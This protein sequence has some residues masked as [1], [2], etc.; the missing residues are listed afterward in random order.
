MTRLLLLLALAPGLAFA[1]NLDTDLEGDP[2][3]AATSD[4]F[5]D[6]L[7]GVTAVLATVALVHGE[8][9]AYPRTTFGLLGSRQAG[10]TGL[11]ARSLSEMSVTPTA[12]G[13][14]VRYVPLPTAPYVRRDRVVEMTVTLDDGLYSADYEVV[15]REDPDDGGDRIAYDRAGRYLVTRGYGTACADLE[16]VQGQLRDGTFRAE[17]GTLGPRPLTVRVHPVGEDEP[18]FYREVR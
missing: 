17:P 11:R 15:R 4:Q 6:D 13:V 16:V 9:G 10:R 18:V 3:L 7:E 5:Q 2:A 14:T 12:D 8:T 1:Q